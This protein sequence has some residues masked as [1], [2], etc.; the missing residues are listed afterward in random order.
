MNS[1]RQSALFN[2]T[3]QWALSENNKGNT[4]KEDGARIASSQIQYDYNF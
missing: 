1:V 4:E 3:E 2:E